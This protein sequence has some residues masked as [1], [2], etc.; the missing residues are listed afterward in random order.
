MVASLEPLEQALWYSASRSHH[1]SLK[2]GRLH[3]GEYEGLRVHSCIITA[4]LARIRVF[5]S[6]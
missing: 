3:H 2:L 1:H 6:R 5:V 4:F